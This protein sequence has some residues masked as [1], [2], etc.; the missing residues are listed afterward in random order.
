MK[1]IY[2]GVQHYYSEDTLRVRWW[3]GFWVGVVGS[4]CMMFVVVAALFFMMVRTNNDLQ[5]GLVKCREISQSNY[6]VATA[7]QEENRQLR[8]LVVEYQAQLQKGQAPA[9]LAE[10]LLKLLVR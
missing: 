3:K 9:S 2:D 8:A 6:T 1:T 4:A 7:A 10:F 5:A